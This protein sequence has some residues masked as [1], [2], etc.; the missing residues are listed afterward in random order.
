MTKLKIALVERNDEQRIVN[1][2]DE[3][4]YDLA[5]CFIAMA[6]E[7][8]IDVSSSN[9]CIPDNLEEF[10]KQGDTA[11]NNSLKAVDWAENKDI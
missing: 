2:N 8:N 10:I 7:T 6:K 11:I 5:N 4:V 3:T 1:I 9:Q